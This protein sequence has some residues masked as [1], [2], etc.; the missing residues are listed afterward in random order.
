MQAGKFFTSCRLLLTFWTV[1]M[2]SQSPFLIELQ[3]K[4]RDYFIL[5][6]LIVAGKAM[7]LLC[8]KSAMSIVCI[9]VYACFHCALLSYT[10]NIV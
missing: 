2:L 3:K 8:I 10:N 7:Q 9:C 6:L 1:I 4:N 5:E